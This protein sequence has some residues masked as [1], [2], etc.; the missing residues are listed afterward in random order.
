MDLDVVEEVFRNCSDS[1]GNEEIYFIFHGGEPLIVGL[2]YFRKIVDYQKN[3]WERKNILTLFKR[4]AQ[5]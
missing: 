3:I 5:C 2:E 4:M 1:N